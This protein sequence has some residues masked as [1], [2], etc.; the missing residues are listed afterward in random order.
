MATTTIQ[1]S[2]IEAPRT[3]G[4]R[5]ADAVRQA[6][7]ASH[8]ARLFKSLAEDAVEDGIYAAKRSLT[9]T[10]RRAAD[11]KDAA[12]YRVRRRPLQIV[13]AAFGIGLT[14]GVVVGLVARRSRRP[15]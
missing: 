5:A 3:I 9:T 1:P 12:V 2:E 7:H 4:D 11:L 10:V 8:K 13:G 6:A 14:L 15:A